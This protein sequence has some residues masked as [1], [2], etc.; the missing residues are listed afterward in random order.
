MRSIAHHVKKY[1]TSFM[2]ASYSSKKTPRHISKIPARVLHCVVHTLLAIVCLLAALSN[3]VFAH[4]ILMGIFLVWFLLEVLTLFF[5][6][7]LKNKLHILCSLLLPIVGYTAIT[8]Y[9][10]IQAHVEGILTIE[11][12]YP[13]ELYKPFASKKLPAVDGSARSIQWEEPLPHID[14]IMSLYPLYAAFVQAVYP[15][16]SYDPLPSWNNEAQTFVYKNPLVLCSEREAAYENLFNGSADIIF[17]TEPT[18]EEHLRAQERGYSLYLTPIAKDAFVFFVNA[19]NPVKNL[20]TQQIQGIYSGLLTNWKA[21][22][23]EKVS[24]DILA[25]QREANSPSQ[26]FLQDLMGD[27]PL[28]RPRREE[29][30]ELLY[31]TQGTTE[32]KE[33]AVLPYRN[34]RAALGYSLRSCA[35]ES[36]SQGKISLLSL[37]GIEPTD[38]NIRTDTYQYTVMV[39][40]ITTGHDGENTK[41]FIDWILSAQ[42]QDIVHKSGWVHLFYENRGEQ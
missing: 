40:A 42:G 30:T 35:H 25:F 41:R 8:V 4:H 34:Y 15:E 13:L 6:F 17:C 39:Y 3:L 10:G 9:A 21:L 2:A 18:L 32:Q 1:Y 7:P 22:G 23:T 16:A 38:A 24:R 14:G 19:H 28:A 36:L 37:D 11:E 20:T 31:K 29:S 33:S 27:I 26:L 12:T 5:C